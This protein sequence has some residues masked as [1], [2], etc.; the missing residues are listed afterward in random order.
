MCA[1]DLRIPVVQGG[2]NVKQ[3]IIGG[4]HGDPAATL[5][6]RVVQPHQE[7]VPSASQKP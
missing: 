1:F 6:S 2:E 5:F 3:E 7:P 4:A